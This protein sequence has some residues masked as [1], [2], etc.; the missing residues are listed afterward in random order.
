MCGVPQMGILSLKQG[1]VVKNSCRKTDT[2]RLGTLATN[3]F[4]YFHHEPVPADDRVFAEVVPRNFC[5]K[6]LG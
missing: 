4:V 1:A 2:R 6:S 3:A 5:D